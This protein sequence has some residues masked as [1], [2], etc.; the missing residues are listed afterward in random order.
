MP[1]SVHSKRHAMVATALADQR[2][3]SG[4]T[5][6]QVASALGRYQPFVANIESGERRVDI[7]EL[8]DLAD[9]VGL[10]VIALIQRLQLEKR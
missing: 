5:Q 7:I 3:A 9:I 8:I 1:K 2:R 4:L 10:D 6:A